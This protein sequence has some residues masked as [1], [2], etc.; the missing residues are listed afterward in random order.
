MNALGR[1]EASNDETLDK[2]PTMLAKQ[3]RI[4]VYGSWYN[5]YLCEFR[6]GVVLPSEIIDGLNLTPDVQQRKISYSALIYGSYAVSPDFR[7]LY[8]TF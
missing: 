1:L 5:Y 3:T 2:L 6:G 7:Y 8:C 4:G